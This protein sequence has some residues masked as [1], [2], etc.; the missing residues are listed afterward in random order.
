MK[1][2]RPIWGT[3]TIIERW[4]NEGQCTNVTAK[5]GIE[6]RGSLTNI[7]GMSLRTPF[8]SKYK[9]SACELEEE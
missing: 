7:S 8:Q 4:E 3:Q 2:N 5:M 9:Q 1:E 6:K